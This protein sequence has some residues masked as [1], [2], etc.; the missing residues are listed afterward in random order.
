MNAL[1][2]LIRASTEIGCDTQLIQGAGGNTSL[3]VGEV[4]W[5]KA[6]GRWLSRAT[7]EA[8]FVPVSLPGVREGI[9]QGQ[10]DPVGAQ[11]RD[12]L[13]PPEDRGRLR[14]SIET[15]L[16]ALM[17]HA[18]V[19]HV[20]SVAA[21]AWAVQPGGEALLASR[22]QGFQWAWVPYA[23]PGLPLTRAVVRVL[24]AGGHKAPADVLLLGHHGLVV[25][26]EGP[27]QAL[28]RLREVEACL[29]LPAR[30]LGEVPS[31]RLTDAIR[32]THYRLPD[33][34]S[35]HFLGLDPRATALAAGG[36]LY[37]D[38]VVFLGGGLPVLSTHSPGAGARAWLDIRAA[39]AVIA[40]GLGVWV[41]EDLPPGGQAMLHCLAE[42]LRRLPTDAV[43]SYLPQE[44]VD[45]LRQW[46]A[47]KF[48]QQ[49]N[50][51]RA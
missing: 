23:R 43:V 9:A 37:P 15:T 12:D 16:H 25:G 51:G 30:P 32:G 6:S 50:V 41:H 22:L 19:L 7:D 44:E 3:K 10:P 34:P 39:P 8:L 24:Q 21:I 20:H 45:G 33:E 13:L 49:Q 27:E 17:P 11:V 26:G 42:V 18:A 5:V 4:L 47:E 2:S 1:T 29:A 28:R 36:A 40:E 35:C 31:A 48:R 46:D 38:H 14:P